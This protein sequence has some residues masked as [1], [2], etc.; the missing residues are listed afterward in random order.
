MKKQLD[1]QADRSLKV[2]TRRQVKASGGLEAA[3]RV[4]RVSSSRLSQYQ[5]IDHDS[6]VPIDVVV[7]LTTDSKEAHALEAM[8]ATCGYFLLPVD[9]GESG[10]L[11]VDFAEFGEATAQSFADYQ[12]ALSEALSNNG[13]LTSKDKR[14]LE[15]DFMKIAHVVSHILSN[16]KKS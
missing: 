13:H 14:K 2:A 3:A 11:S 7:D 9:F 10:Q 12:R 15:D 1:P 16:L 4:S 5:S 6:Y 8:A